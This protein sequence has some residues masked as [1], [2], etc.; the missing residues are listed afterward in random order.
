MSYEEKYEMLERFLRTHLNY[1][2]Y[3]EYSN[4]L[5]ELCKLRK[6]LADHVIVTMYAECPR[7][8][9]EMIEFARDIEAAHGIKEVG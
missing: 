9:A 6:P 2:D 4:A 7:S 1:D 8:D 5:A 3:A